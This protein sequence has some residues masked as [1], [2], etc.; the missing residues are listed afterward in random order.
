M[1]WASKVW[2]PIIL[3]A[4]VFL[5]LRK[6]QTKPSLYPSLPLPSAFSLSPPLLC[7]L[8]EGITYSHGLHFF[9]SQPF[10]FHHHLHRPSNT[11]FPRL[12][13]MIL[14]PTLVLI[15]H[16]H[17]PSSINQETELVSASPSPSAAYLG[18][19]ESFDFITKTYPES[20]HSSPLLPAWSESPSPLIRATALPPHWPPCTL[21]VALQSHTT[22]W[23]E[24]PF[25]P[26]DRG[27]LRA[28][29]PLI[30]RAFLCSLSG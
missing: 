21:S 2:L 17:L 5:V 3:H 26:K 19:P 1:G 30:S 12:H 28:L 14:C 6:Q 10:I 16:H 8:F 27:Q 29:P 7:R 23:P 18:H 22:L 20:I 11:T 24:R 9:L 25:S 4:Q 13:S 15:R